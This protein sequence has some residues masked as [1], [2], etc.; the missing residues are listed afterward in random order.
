MARVPLIGQTA[1]HQMTHRPLGEELDPFFTREIMKSP[2]KT[3]VLCE[4]S[5]SK[6]LLTPSLPTLPPHRRF[7]VEPTESVGDGSRRRDRRQRGRRRDRR[8]DRGRRGNLLSPPRRSPSSSRPSVRQRTPKSVV[9]KQR[10][11]CS[12]QLP[13]YF[14]FSNINLYMSVKAQYI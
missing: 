1:P 3:K 8:R 10:S 2:M 9:L 7:S 11:F 14:D 12:L 6:F 13:A 4:W 5:V